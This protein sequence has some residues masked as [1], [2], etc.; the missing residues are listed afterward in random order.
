MK[1][2]L[3]VLILIFIIICLLIILYKGFEEGLF[4]LT[5][6]SDAE[7]KANDL[8]TQEQNASPVK[9]TPDWWITYEMPSCYKP[10]VT[11]PITAL[12]SVRIHW[13]Q[14]I[15]DQPVQGTLLADD[16]DVIYSG[17][18]SGQHINL[19]DQAFYKTILNKPLFF[20]ADF[21]KDFTSLTGTYTIN[22]QI[23]TEGCPD[24]TDVTGK[25]TGVPCQNLDG[26]GCP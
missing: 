23:N 5:K 14:L 7:Q 20:S 16:A 24:G 3:G 25:V 15:A 21:S 4:K 13:Q 17:T 19:T 1:K 26:Y 2:R 11:E 6:L 9:N 22:G 12:G 8:V 10:T 18:F